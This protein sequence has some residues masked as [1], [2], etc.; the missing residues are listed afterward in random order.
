MNSLSRT[1][2]IILISV[3]FQIS[4]TAQEIKRKTFTLEQAVQTAIEM[5]AQLR[6]QKYEV[7]RAN[8]KVSEAWGTALPKVDITANYQ[9]ALKKPVFFFPDI[10][11]GTNRLMAIEIGATNSYATSLTAS[12]ILFNAAV[13]TGISTA[14]IYSN[15]ARELYNSKKVEIVTSVRKAFSQALLAREALK[16]M[17]EVLKNAEDNL[18]SVKVRNK[19]GIISD[20][21]LLRAEVAVDNIRPL[22]IQAEN[23]VSLSL[24][25][26]KATIGLGGS[27]D[28]S[29]E[30]ELT[31]QPVD[32]SLLQKAQNEI[33]ALNI[34]LRAIRLQKEVN[35]AFVSIERSGY[36]PTLAAFYNYQY[37]A[38]RNPN[39]ISTNDFIASSIVGLSF[40]INIFN[41]IQTNSRIEQAK[42]EVRKTEETI[43]GVEANLTTAV[44]SVVSLINQSRKRIEVQ[45][46]TVEQAQK[47]YQLATTRYQNG[48]ST[49]LEVNDAQV[50]LT[51]AKVNRMQAIFDYQNALADLDQLIGRLP[52]YSETTK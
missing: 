37:Q 4:S 31:F 12:Q 35:D 52:D 23:G 43:R 39:V 6:S 40:S 36:I 20:Y 29:I 1:I 13:I 18:A 24:D 16:M 22:V 32:D 11:G 34:P 38:Q 46:K 50:A 2:L 8:A 48:L 30:G 41:G 14:S 42:L 19:K 49:Q 10:F 45:Q 15:A 5:N 51:Q 28:I 47:G 44:H 25:N 3:L 26:L 27:E 7:D 21:D 9:R 17:K 33:L